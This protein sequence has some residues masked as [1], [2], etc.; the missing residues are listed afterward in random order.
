[1]THSPEQLAFFSA[2]TSSSDSLILSA[3]AGSGKTTTI[4]SAC[5]LLPLGL[6]IRFLA[7]NKSIKEEL[8]RR[9]PPTI[10]VS[11]FH[12]EGLRAWSA[13]SK[14]SRPQI[15][16]DKMRNILKDE[17][18]EPRHK[19][20]YLSFCSRLSSY[21]KGAGLG[22]EFADL[23]IEN[24]RQL[25]SH[26]SLFPEDDTLD[27][28]LAL[29]YVIRAITRSN[30]LGSTVL[31]FDD[32]L[33][34]PLIHS[35]PFP[36]ANI[37]FID[38][39]QDTNFVQRELLKQILAPA[40]HGRLI[41]VG[42]PNQA[43]YGFRGADSEA[44]NRLKEEFNM[45]SLPLSVSWRCSKAVVREAR[46][47][48]ELITHSPDAP[49][50]SVLH[51]K[52]YTP[53]DFPSTSAVL[54]RNNSPLISFAFSLIERGVGVRVAGRDFAK[55]LTDLINKSKSRDLS[56][57]TQKLSASRDRERRR[58]IASDNPAAL[59]AIDD[60]YNCL[61]LFLSRAEDLPDLLSD[62]TSLFSDTDRGLLT[63]STVHKAKGLEWSKVFI[64]D[65]PALM[66][67]RFAKL[68]WQKQQELNLIYVA[69]TRAKL[70]LVYINS[71][72]WKE[73]QVSAVSQP[74]PEP[75]PADDI[76]F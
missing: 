24:L 13:F 50:G 32:M 49:D 40:P 2:L 27:E 31:D 15:D 38:E 39:A 3:V 65:A 12:S 48:S 60:K 9:L 63:L 28:S 72:C 64:L 1:M 67:A 37:I 6:S 18:L 23:S 51:L 70:D 11:T 76:P 7:F 26:H 47:N 52:S 33:Y 57:L 56:E 41:A 45:T 74:T 16:G 17:V 30:E 4:V 8:E 71:N 20:S 29:K 5:R 42:D 14:P 35:I 55:Q 25:I 66:P 59:S 44:M 61:D 22:T 53:E 69:V 19:F 34:L 54:C 46:Q 10:T 68:P 62:I 21:A 58:A 43:I 73:D 75:E 36:R